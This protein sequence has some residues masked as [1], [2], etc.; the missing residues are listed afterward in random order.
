MAKSI[1]KS[2]W[3]PAIA[4]AISVL[5]FGAQAQTGTGTGT[6]TTQGEMQR[7]VPG[8]DVDTR[9]T[10]RPTP[11]GVPGVDVDVRNRDSRT[12]ERRANEVETRRSGAGADMMTA[13]ERRARA[14]RN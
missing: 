6:S 13:D 10:G 3:T 12:G 9:A 8:V 7:G 2:L 4:A 1:S 5:A 14:D 11:G